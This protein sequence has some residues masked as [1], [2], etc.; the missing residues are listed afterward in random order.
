MPRWLTRFLHWS[1]I[2]RSPALAFH[3][4]VK[5]IDWSSVAEGMAKYEDAYRKEDGARILAWY[6]AREAWRKANE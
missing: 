4:S 6:E 3:D 5:N 2:V 1:H